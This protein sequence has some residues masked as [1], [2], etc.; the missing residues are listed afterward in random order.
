ERVLDDRARVADV[1]PTLPFRQDTHGAIEKPRK[2]GE[3][4]WPLVIETACRMA[5]SQEFRDRRDVLGMRDRELAQIDL[6]SG[7]A[8]P[9]RRQRGDHAPVRINTPCASGVSAFR[10]CRM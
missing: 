4:Y 3:D 6:P 8:R 9:H 10:A 7:P 5:L 2:L 1:A